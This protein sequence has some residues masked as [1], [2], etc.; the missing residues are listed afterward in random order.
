MF[1]A[2]RLYVIAGGAIV[3]GGLALLRFATRRKK[4]AEDHERERRELL[5]RIGRLVDGTVIDVA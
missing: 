1:T 2:F 3:I 5:D 4:S